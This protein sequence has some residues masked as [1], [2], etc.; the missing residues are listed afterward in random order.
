MMCRHEHIWN[1]EVLQQLIRT[2]HLPLGEVLNLPRQRQDKQDFSFA[3]PHIHELGKNAYEQTLQIWPTRRKFIVIKLESYF[4]E[5]IS[6]CK[7]AVDARF[8][9]ISKFVSY[10]LCLHVSLAIVRAVVT[11]LCRVLL[12]KI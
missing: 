12:S 7:L 10:K 4:L 5:K 2:T 6:S 3:C 9:F 8:L 11:T 1:I